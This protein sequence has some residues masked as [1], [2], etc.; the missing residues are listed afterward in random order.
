MF[1]VLNQSDQELLQDLQVETHRASGPGGTKSDTTESAVRL[2]HPSSDISV[3]INKTRSQQQNKSI[4]LERFRRRYALKVRH[5]ID[6]DQI[7]IPPGVKKFIN[8]GFDI[9]R[10]NQWFPFLV[11]F[12]LDVFQACEGRVS[13]TA[14]ILDTSTGQ[15]VKFMKAHNAV[16]KHANRIREKFDLHRLH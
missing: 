12:V 1:E 6:P 7:G 3:Q 13:D 5:E 16:W 14:D 4:A 2:T 10:K 8:S 11:K 9:N 15:L